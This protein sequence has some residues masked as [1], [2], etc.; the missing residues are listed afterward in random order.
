MQVVALL[1]Q[2]GVQLDFVLDEGL[3]VTEG[4]LPGVKAPL[5]MIR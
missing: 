5:A 3:A 1:K 2:R 4:I